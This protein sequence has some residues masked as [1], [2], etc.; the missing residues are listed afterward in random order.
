M[1]KSDKIVILGALFIAG[2]LGLIYLNTVLPSMV[3]QHAL[4]TVLNDLNP[5]ETRAGETDA[6][7]RPFLDVSY[8][9]FKNK[10]SQS[11]NKTVVIDGGQLL[12]ET[13]EGEE[14]YRYR[15]RVSVKKGFPLCECT[16][17][18]PVTGE[19]ES[20][21]FVILQGTPRFVWVP[22]Y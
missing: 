7:P 20:Y 4:R 9:G 8:R 19:T 6:L 18:N 21:G 11:L 15:I 16:W 13:P 10:Y 2:F 1:D 3:R 14:Y 17:N 5:E 22:S 12:L